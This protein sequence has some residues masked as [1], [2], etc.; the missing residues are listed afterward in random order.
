M[1]CNSCKI[2]GE[3]SELKQLMIRLSAMFVWFDGGVCNTGSLAYR[4]AHMDI[5]HDIERIK[6]PWEKKGEKSNKHIEPTNES[7]G[8]IE[9]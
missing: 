4:F 9:S 8:K 7:S 6:F 5:A 2:S 3:L 1:K